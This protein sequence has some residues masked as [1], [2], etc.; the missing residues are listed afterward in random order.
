MRLDN[1]D[2]GTA[3]RILI[4]FS[5]NL[6]SNSPEDRVKLGQTCRLTL[7]IEPRVLKVEVLIKVLMTS[8][9]RGL[10]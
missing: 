2:V 4:K 1:G 5:S 3:L 6:A 8:E 9:F 10:G 7:G